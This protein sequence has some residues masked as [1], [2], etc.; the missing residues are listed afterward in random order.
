MG[1]L[2]IARMLQLNDTQ[3]GVLALAFKYADDN[4][5]L[6]LDLK[7]L[8]SLMQFVGEN[9][10]ELTTQVRQCFEGV[11]RCDPARACCRSTSRAAKTFLASRP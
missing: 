2:L 7:D 1:P 5:L 6:L 10:D 3:E 4:G 8:Q 9:A 11:G